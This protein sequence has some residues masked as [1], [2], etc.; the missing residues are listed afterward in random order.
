MKP[1]GKRLPSLLL[2]A[3]LG[4]VPATGALGGC[5]SAAA[6][7]QGVL[8]NPGNVTSFIQ[9][10]LTFLQGVAALWGAIFPFIPAASQAKAQADFDSAVY[11]VEQALAALEDAVRAAAA[12]HQSNPDFSAIISNVQ[13]AVASLVKIAEQWQGTQQANAAPGAPG[14]QD[15]VR[16]AGVIASWK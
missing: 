12:A 2:C 11:S 14:I 15:I 10:V 8:A 13:A 16:Q 4:G 9:Y 5:A 7:W 3:L 1:S 6:W